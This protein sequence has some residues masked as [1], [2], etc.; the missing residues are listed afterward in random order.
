MGKR[1][2]KTLSHGGGLLAPRRV[3]NLGG[4]C[5][6]TSHSPWDQPRQLY[7]PQREDPGL[8]APEAQSS[9]ALSRGLP[10]NHGLE[11]VPSRQELEFSGNGPK[12]AGAQGV[13]RE[14]SLPRAPGSICTDQSVSQAP[15]MGRN[16]QVITAEEHKVSG[17][18]EI[19]SEGERLPDGFTSKIKQEPGAE[20]F[21]IGAPRL[22]QS[23]NAYDFM[24]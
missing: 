9:G 6:R 16:A 5:V 10:M 2:L 1:V 4:V 14:E 13:G 7:P 12:M 20:H 22:K 19:E 15:L 8:P 24:F 18:A 17:P 21:I 3:Q 23:V 11:N